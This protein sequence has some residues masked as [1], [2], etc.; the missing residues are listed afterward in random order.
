MEICYGLS[1]VNDRVHFSRA[2]FIN[3]LH[4]TDQ[5]LHP[6]K[7]LGSQRFSDVFKGYWI[8]LVHF[9]ITLQ[10]SLVIVN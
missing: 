4:A 1:K 10:Q 9:Y 5:I 6:L 7:K 2:K 3:L 8:G